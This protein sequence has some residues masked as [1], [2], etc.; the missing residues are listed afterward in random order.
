[1]ERRTEYFAMG[2]FTD[3][4]RLVNHETFRLAGFHFELDE[5]LLEGQLLG[6]GF[7][8]SSDTVVSQMNCILCLVK[9]LFGRG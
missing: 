5:L 3:L 8:H 1:M 4:H 6:C 9:V 2:A 7:W